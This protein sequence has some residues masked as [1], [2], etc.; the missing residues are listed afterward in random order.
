M[1][2]KIKKVGLT[3]LTCNKIDFK[4]KA[5][6]RDKEG[7]YVIIKGEIQQQDITLVNIYAPNIRASKYVKQIL[8]D[9][10]KETDNN[11]V[12]VGTSMIRSSRQKMSKA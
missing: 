9:K 3:I 11:T 1:Q 7:H 10:M 4:T 8:M 2:L 12:I 5:I 6:V